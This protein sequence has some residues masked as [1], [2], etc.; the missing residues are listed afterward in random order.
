MYYSGRE[1]TAMLTKMESK[2]RIEEEVL[3]LI[4][5]SSQKEFSSLYDVYKDN[6]NKVSLINEKCRLSIM[7]HGELLTAKLGNKRASNVKKG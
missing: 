4:E 7:N 2:K 1:F 3:K 6:P 5:E